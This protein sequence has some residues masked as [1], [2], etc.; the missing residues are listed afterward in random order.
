MY[1]FKAVSQDEMDK[2]C[3]VWKRLYS[4]EVFIRNNK[5]DTLR[6]PCGNDE[7]LQILLNDGSGYYVNANQRN[8]RFYGQLRTML[9]LIKTR[10]IKRKILWHT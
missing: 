3:G 1:L 10:S 8:D 4:D 2:Y 9:F 6:Q 5:S 7:P